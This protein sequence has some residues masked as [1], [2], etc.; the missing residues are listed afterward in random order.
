MTP[1]SFL[2]MHTDER[3]AVLTKNLKYSDM[4]L[5]ADMQKLNI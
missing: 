3:E 2:V 1:A 4:N 5:V